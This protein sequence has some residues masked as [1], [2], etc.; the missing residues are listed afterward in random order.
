MAWVSYSVQAVGPSYPRFSFLGHHTLNGV[1]WVSYSVQAVGLLYPGFSFLGH[2]TLDGVAWASYSVQAVG[3]LYPLLVLGAP[4]PERCGV[5]EL[6]RSGCRA[7]L[8]SLIPQIP[9]P[10]HRFNWCFPQS[11]R[12]DGLLIPDIVPR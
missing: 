11:L 2:Y 4:H 12:V 5:G 3:L 10:L 8:L 9:P 1:A 7:V 6:Q